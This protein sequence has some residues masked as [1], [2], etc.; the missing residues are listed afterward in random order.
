MTP[1]VTEQEAG[2][3][4]HRGNLRRLPALRVCQLT[5]GEILRQAQ[6]LLRRMQET[7]QVRETPNTTE[8]T[9]NGRRR[10][11]PRCLL[12]L[13]LLRIG[14]VRFRTARV[15]RSKTPD[16]ESPRPSGGSGRMSQHSRRGGAR[17]APS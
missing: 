8:V 5:S 6:Q 3:I 11:D 15:G 17:Y 16:E 10:L 14:V 12:W 4:E 7:E 1:K 9:L 13:E 2:V